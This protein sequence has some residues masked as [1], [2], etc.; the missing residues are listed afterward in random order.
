ML[1]TSACDGH[2][3]QPKRRNTQDDH[4]TGEAGLHGMCSQPETSTLLLLLQLQIIC[5]AGPQGTLNSA[6]QMRMCL[7][8]CHA[9]LLGAVEC[10]L[11]RLTPEVIHFSNLHLRTYI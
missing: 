8:S 11:S 3:G 10:V 7:T 2:D 9:H 6:K 1:N 4:A 5:S